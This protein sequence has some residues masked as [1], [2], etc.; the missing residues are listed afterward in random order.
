MRCAYM[1]T[2]AWTEMTREMLN[3][4]GSGWGL[5][6]ELGA[7]GARKRAVVHPER[8][9]LH[10]TVSSA[11]V[12]MIGLTKKAIERRRPT[13]LTYPAYLSHGPKGRPTFPRPEGPPH[14]PTARRAAH[15]P[16][17]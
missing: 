10:V 15:L 12:E 9:D 1:S 11:S 17:A 3:R 4:R 7:R 14:L 2:E 8:M 5:E 16:T 6:A 13:Y